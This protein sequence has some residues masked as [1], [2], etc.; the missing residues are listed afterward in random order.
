MTRERAG[1]IKT[2]RLEHLGE[3]R[4]KARARKKASR[5]EPLQAT[6]ALETAI[7][8]LDA[9]L[10]EKIEDFKITCDVIVIEIWFV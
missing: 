5:Q 9:F 10:T 8:G 2:W 3:R 4:K 6:L 7:D 1:I